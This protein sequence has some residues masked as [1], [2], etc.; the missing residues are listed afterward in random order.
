M[1]SE[2]W[3][4]PYAYFMFNRPLICLAIKCIVNKFNDAIS[5]ACIHNSECSP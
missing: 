5:N 1:H 2:Y 4:M 3:E